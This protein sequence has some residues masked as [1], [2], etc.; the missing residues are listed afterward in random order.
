[1]GSLA[2][3]VVFSA[4][5]RKLDPEPACNFVQ[6]GDL[7]RVSWNDVTPVKFY[8]HKSFP[9]ETYPEME[10]VIREAAASWNQIVGRE[11]IRIE[12]F[13]AGGDGVPKKDG[14]SMLYWMTTWEAGKTLE[15][16]RTTIYW[17]GTQIYEADIR[18]NARDHYYY[19]GDEEKF[20]GVD[21]KSL[22]VHEFG[23]ALGLAHT[24]I[25]K[26]VMNVSLSSGVDRRDISKD[27]AASLRCEY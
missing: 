19:V 6:N 9:L 22:M 24:A 1:M 12:A 20:S 10:K 17:S 13:Q 27:D 18:V 26:S 16:A 25:A 14:Y 4:C 2:L 23:H 11:V 15:Q 3:T 21:F 5:A 7:Q 8:V